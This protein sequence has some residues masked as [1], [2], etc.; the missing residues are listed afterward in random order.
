MAAASLIPVNPSSLTP[1]FGEAIMLK[2]KHQNGPSLYQLIADIFNP[3]ATL[4]KNKRHLFY[5]VTKNL[6]NYKNA[7]AVSNSS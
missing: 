5:F 2:E 4:K 6:Q 7:A 3:D 1:T